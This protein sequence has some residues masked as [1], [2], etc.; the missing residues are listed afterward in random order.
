MSILVALLSSSLV[1]AAGF[2]SG[3]NFFETRLF[4]EVTVLCTYPGR[5]GSRM[6][7]CRGETLD[8]VEF[9][10]FVLDEYVPASKIILKSREIEI[11]KKMAYVSEKKRSKKQFNLWVW[12]LFQRPLLQYGENNIVYQLLDGSKIVRDGEFKVSVQ[13]GEDRQCRHRVMHSSSPDDCDFGSRS[14]CDE[15][16]RL[17][18]YCE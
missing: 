12:T 14:I 16:F 9:D 8:P 1:N 5:G 10:Y 15:Y 11:T 13:R 7:Y 6:V 18:N 3:N 2:S 17:E 4:G